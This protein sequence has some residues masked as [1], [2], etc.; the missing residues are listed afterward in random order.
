MKEDNYPIKYAVL[1]LRE[2]GRAY[3]VTRGY[4][5][6]K[7]Y[8][9][10]S[11]IKNYG[12]RKSKIVHKVVFPFSNLAVFKEALCRNYQD[13]GKKE[14]PEINLDGNVD[15]S[16]VHYVSNLYN[17]YEDAK[18]EA[19]EKNKEMEAEI[20]L[21]ISYDRKLRKAK[22]KFKKEMTICN[23]FGK[24]AL[25]STEDMKITFE[26]DEDLLLKLTKYKNK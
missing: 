11:I 1:K 9:A 15:L 25:A 16:C 8:V 2:E 22:Q 23:F 24:I 3:S 21:C 18:K 7:C 26:Y 4:I 12:D 5:V 10:E 20:S 6:E 13:I 19:D 14:V 17:T